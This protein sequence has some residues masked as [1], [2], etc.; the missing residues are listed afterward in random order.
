MAKVYYLKCPACSKQYYLEDN[1]HN[2]IMSEPTKHKL[3]CPYCK[4]NF[5]YEGGASR[6][7]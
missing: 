2:K 3:K 7:N 6:N 1:L 5:Y 4:K